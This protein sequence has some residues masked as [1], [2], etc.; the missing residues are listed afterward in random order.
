MRIGRLVNTFWV[1]ALLLFLASCGGMDNGGTGG[2]GGGSTVPHLGGGIGGSGDGDGDAAQGNLQIV[3]A[4]RQAAGIDSLLVSMAGLEV[5]SADAAS[6]EEGW[7]PLEL[8]EQ[9]LD[10]VSLVDGRMSVLADTPLA[11]GSYD[12]IRLGFANATVDVLG[13]SYAMSIVGDGQTVIRPDSGISVTDT[14]PTVVNLDFDAL[15]SIQIVGNT[16][17][18]LHPTLNAVNPAVLGAIEGRVR[19]LGIGAE[20]RV[21]YEPAGQL[22][23]AVNVRGDGTFDVPRL[24]VYRPSGSLARYQVVASAPGHRISEPYQGVTLMPG[25]SDDEFDFELDDDKYSD[26]SDYCWWWEENGSSGTSGSGTSG[27]SGSGTS[28][29]D[30]SGSD[31]SGS[32]GSGTSG[33]GSSGSSGSGHDDD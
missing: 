19:P 18:M 29:S 11:A 27:S 5:H 8:Q 15:Q 1:A 10:V 2:G 16:N 28:G 9:D 13:M 6:N 32:S 30:S 3:I 12:A 21:Y 14:E 17:Y 25:Q 7:I 20:V 4:G 24:P 23:A 33:S 31:S 22:V 26:G